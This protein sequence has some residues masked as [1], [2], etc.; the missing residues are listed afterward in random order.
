MAPPSPSLAQA[1]AVG[2]AAT[3]PSMMAHGVNFLPALLHCAW[4][5]GPA[6]VVMGAVSGEAVSRV[7]LYCKSDSPAHPAEESEDD[8]A[9]RAAWEQPMQTQ[10]FGGQHAP[11]QLHEDDS[12]GWGAG[13]TALFFGVVQYTLSCFMACCSIPWGEAMG[14]T[15]VLI[16]L[17]PEL[18]WLGLETGNT[19]A[20]LDARGLETGS[21]LLF[22]RPPTHWTAS[23][24]VACGLL[25][26]VILV[27]F[28]F[29]TQA[30]L[31]V[32]QSFGIEVRFCC[33]WSM[34][35][36]ATTL[37]P[38]LRPAVAWDAYHSADPGR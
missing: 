15:T 34:L 3:Y 18:P 19:A 28:W 7:I 10:A 5:Y 35:G 11:P 21:S 37:P 8:A 4:T 38:F 36:H 14:H 1:F 2:L 25:C 13:A 32:V 20:G 17:A 27:R 24:G 33:P 30:V 6:L 22:W 23:F 29:M 31:V 12:K 26:F 9:F 16:A